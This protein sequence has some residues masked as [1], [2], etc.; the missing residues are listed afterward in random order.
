MERLQVVVIEVHVVI[1][2]VGDEIP[3]WHSR[4]GNRKAMRRALFF[5]IRLP[6]KQVLKRLHQLAHAGIALVVGDEK[7]NAAY[8]MRQM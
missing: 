3:N 7:V 5:L 1:R 6:C 2:V 4:H 8:L